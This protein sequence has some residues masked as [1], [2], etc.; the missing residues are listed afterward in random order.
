MNDYECYK[1]HMLDMLC[2]RAWISA[3]IFRSLL[4][5]QSMWQPPVW[6]S[7]MWLSR[8]RVLSLSW[9]GR[10]NTFHTF[11]SS[12]HFMLVDGDWQQSPTEC[13][14]YK[15]Y[16]HGTATHRKRTSRL[17]LKHITLTNLFLHNYMLLEYYMCKPQL[18]KHP[19]WLLISKIG[20]GAW[21]PHNFPW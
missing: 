6:Q 15:S 14:V 7:S 20:T 9:G 10:N 8:S 2:N 11:V 18:Y 1:Y 19:L 12:K 21:H 3:K 17:G 5:K 4:S 13:V 16:K